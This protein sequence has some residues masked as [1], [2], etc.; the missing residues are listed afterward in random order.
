MGNSGLEHILAGIISHS[1]EWV[2][3]RATVSKLVADILEAVKA[4]LLPRNM[5]QAENNNKAARAILALLL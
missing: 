5:S 3:A 1:T 4:M 2:C